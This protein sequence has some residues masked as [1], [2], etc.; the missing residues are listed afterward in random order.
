VAALALV[1]DIPGEIR[2]GKKAH[3]PKNAPT[4]V[5]APPLGTCCKGERG[6]DALVDDEPAVRSV[7]KR[8]T[9]SKWVS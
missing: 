9:S 3:L 6:R 2:S 5:I 7:G 8:T 1:V 4:K